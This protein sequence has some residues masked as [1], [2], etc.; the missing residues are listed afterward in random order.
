MDVNR[1]GDVDR[2]AETDRRVCGVD[3]DLFPSVSFCFL[4]CVFSST[5]R[6]A[7]PKTEAHTPLSPKGSG[8]A[9]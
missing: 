5:P 6:V 9:S 4:L 1:R 3:V 7:M 2:W 8:C